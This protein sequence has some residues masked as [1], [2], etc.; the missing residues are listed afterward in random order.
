MKLNVWELKQTVLILG[1]LCVDF[2]KT[3]N[4]FPLLC[5]KVAANFILCSKSQCELHAFTENHANIALIY[6][7]GI[8]SKSVATITNNII[9]N[10]Q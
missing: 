1:S 10:R 9:H 8:M 6:N 3:E 4:T 7:Q 5:Q 2:I